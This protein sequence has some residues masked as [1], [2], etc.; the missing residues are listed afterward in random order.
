VL[1]GLQFKLL[2]SALATS[3]SLEV[4]DLSGN[5]IKGGALP[6]E[7]SAMKNLTALR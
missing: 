4:L 2:P 1:Q 6:G 7:L 3:S 5:T